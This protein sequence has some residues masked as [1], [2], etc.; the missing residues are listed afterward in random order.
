MTVEKKSNLM[1]MAVAG[2]RV[3]QKVAHE[4]A[5]SKGWWDEPRTDGELVV[6]MHSELSEVVEALRDGNPVS[7]KIPPHTKR[8]EELAD[9]VIR[10][11]DYAERSNIDLGKVIVDKMSYNRGRPHRHGGKAF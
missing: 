4:I 7:E 10:V 8:D 2:I 1:T 3:L 9:V 6:L 5:K 11:L